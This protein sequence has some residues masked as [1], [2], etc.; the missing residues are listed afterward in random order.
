MITCSHGDCDKPQVANSRYCSY[1]KLVHCHAVHEPHKNITQ[2]VFVPQRGAVVFDPKCADPYH[3][4]AERAREHLKNDDFYI[5]T[6]V[7]FANDKVEVR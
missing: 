7:Q 2:G 6:I 1:H 5:G 3:M 4:S